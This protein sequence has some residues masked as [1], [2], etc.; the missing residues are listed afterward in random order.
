MKYRKEAILKID[1]LPSISGSASK[2]LGML[3]D[4][5]TG[6]EQ[7]VN[8]VNHD[9][10]LTANILK[11][12]NSAYFGM[13]SKVGSVQKA[14][15]IL[16]VKNIRRIV[17][18]ACYNSMLVKPVTGYDLPPGDLWR[19]SIAVS[20]VAEGLAKELEIPM[21]D[22][23]FTAALLHDVGKL[24]LGS[25]V[26]EELEEIEA[27][28]LDGASFY[29]AEQ[30]IL[31]TDHAEIGALILDKWNF[32]DSIVTAVRC[33]HDPDCAD[34]C[35]LLNDVVHSANLL[36]LMMGIGVGRE[37]LRCRLSEGA[38]KR[39]GLNRGSLEVVASKALQWVNELTQS[40]EGE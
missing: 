4:P 39:L 16:G 17:L 34:Q 25:F 37:G 20:V 27:E 40:M 30:K 14:V 11:L 24:I 32:P 2:L 26:N 8:V 21:G 29:E 7:I 5:D 31:G 9:P 22:E 35:S 23:V 36:C 3:D 6:I 15:V 10:G 38:V 13:P 1:S 28:A 19:H 33:H 12:T 18:S